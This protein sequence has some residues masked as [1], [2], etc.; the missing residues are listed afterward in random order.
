MAY[1]LTS[2]L[3]ANTSGFSFLGDGET[4][5]F[6]IFTNKNYL[7][8]NLKSCDARSC[9]IDLFLKPIIAITGSLHDLMRDLHD[10]A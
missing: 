6:C 10:F 9:V 7:H 8:Y 4:Q 1:I 5:E 2:G 3:K